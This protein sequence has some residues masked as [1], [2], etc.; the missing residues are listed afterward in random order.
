MHTGRQFSTKDYDHDH[1]GDHCANLYKG[2][3]WYRSCYQANLNGVYYD[4]G[5][6]SNYDGVNWKGFR[7]V[8]ESMKTTEMKVRGQV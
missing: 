6:H 3:W 7:G 1:Y 2:G 4:G 5:D 8:S